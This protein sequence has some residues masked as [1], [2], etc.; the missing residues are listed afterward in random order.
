MEGNEGRRKNETRKKQLHKRH[1]KT[2]ESSPERNKGSANQR[3]N[4][5]TNQNILQNAPDLKT[6]KK[7]C[8]KQKCLCGF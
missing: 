8:E 7:R 2:R 4:Q 6:E 1:W 3:D 5:T